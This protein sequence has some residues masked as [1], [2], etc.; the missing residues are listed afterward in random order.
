MSSQWCPP[1]PFDAEEEEEEQ[2]AQK[3]GAGSPVS[4]AAPMRVES[5]RSCVVGIDR[6]A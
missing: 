5:K 4:S 6:H 2:F 1:A 3:G